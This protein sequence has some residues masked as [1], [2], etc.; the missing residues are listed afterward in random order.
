MLLAPEEP[1]KKV[2]FESTADISYRIATTRGQRE[3]AFRLV[4]KSY[5]RSGIGDRNRYCMRVTPYHLLPT[6]ATF[7]AEVRGE[8]VFT[9]SLVNDGA[10]GLPMEYVYGE[11]VA[12]MRRRGLRI[13]EVSCLADRRASMVRFFPIFLRTSRLLVQYAHREGLDGLVIAVHPKHARFYRRYFDFRAIG[14]QKDYPCV[15]N[16]PAVALWME[17]ARLQRECSSSYEALLAD[18]FDDE[19][20]RAQPISQAE[21]DYFRPMI[22]PSFHCA[23]IGDAEDES[24]TETAELAE[25]MA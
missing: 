14:G 24:S 10:L 19:E 4:Y 25:C 7:V 12:D 20:L 8:V 23:P 21:C 18:P 11:E 3:A 17:F 9:M 6:T 1:G 22:D 15:R 5:L 2:P 13:G 16:R